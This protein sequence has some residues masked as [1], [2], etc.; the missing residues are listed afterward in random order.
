MQSWSHVSRFHG[1]VVGSGSYSVGR[2]D[3]AMEAHESGHIVP[4]LLVHVLRVT[5]YTLFVC[6]YMVV[7]AFCFSFLRCFLHWNHSGL[8]YKPYF[9]LCKYGNFGLHVRLE[10]YRILTVLVDIN[11]ATILSIGVCRRNHG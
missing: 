8:E 3:K 6:V 9:N 2:R 10:W 4:L 1:F 11:A 5:P 7:C